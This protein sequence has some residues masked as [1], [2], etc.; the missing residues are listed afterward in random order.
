[1]A[2]LRKSQTADYLLNRNIGNVI[3][4]PVIVKDG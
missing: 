4:D 3:L 2:N 1:M